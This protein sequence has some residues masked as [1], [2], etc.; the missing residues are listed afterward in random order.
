MVETGGGG[1]TTGG[2]DTVGGQV[3]R[4]T[5]DDSG[6][7]DDPIATSGGMRSGDCL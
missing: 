6:E 5:T 4:P 3:Y 7:V 1:S 2:G